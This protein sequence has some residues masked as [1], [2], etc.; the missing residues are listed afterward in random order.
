MNSCKS[1]KEEVEAQSLIHIPAST[2]MIRNNT[3]FIQHSV[4]LVIH[5]SVLFNISQESA[6]SVISTIPH[7]STPANPT[8]P[9]AAPA[10]TTHTFL[11]ACAAHPS[12]PIVPAPPIDAHN[13]TGPPSHTPLGGLFFSYRPQA[14]MLDDHCSTTTSSQSGQIKSQIS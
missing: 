3:T 11:P 7:Y 10:D 5:S 9:R 6:A 14:T 8:P 12:A 2:E 1:G 4:F 13:T